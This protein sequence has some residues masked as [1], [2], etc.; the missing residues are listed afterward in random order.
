M[1]EDLSLPLLG[2]VP[3]DPRIGTPGLSVL[4]SDWSEAVDPFSDTSEAAFLQFYINLLVRRRYRFYSG[5]SFVTRTDASH[6]SVSGFC[7][8]TP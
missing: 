8:I 5:S 4:R 2:R 1:C 7:L 3:L 6:R